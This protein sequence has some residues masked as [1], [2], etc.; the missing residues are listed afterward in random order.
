MLKCGNCVVVGSLL[1]LTLIRSNVHLFSEFGW[2]IRVC[3]GGFV[4]AFRTRILDIPFIAKLVFITKRTS[5]SIQRS[6]RLVKRKQEIWGK[7]TL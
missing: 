2:R 1:F 5:K 6:S 7:G 4:F 3:L